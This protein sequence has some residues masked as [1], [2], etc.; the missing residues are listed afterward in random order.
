ML[1][2]GGPVF[3][4]SRD[5]YNY[6]VTLKNEGE[7]EAFIAKVKEK[8]YKAI[9]CPIIDLDNY[10]L[11]DL[12][13]KR[14][15]EEDIIIA[16]AGTWEN[17]L[18]LNL[19]DRAKNRD[20]M[21]QTIL[22]ADAL[23]A[24]TAINT[25]GALNFGSHR[26]HCAANFTEEAFEAVLEQTRELLDRTNPKHTKLSYEIYQWHILDT[27]KEIKRMV[28]AINDDRFGVHLDLVNLLN[29]PRR[30]WRSYDVAKEFIDTLGEH[31]VSC[32][33][34]DVWMNQGVNDDLEFHEVPAGQGQVDIAGCMKLLSALPGEIPYMM[35]HLTSEEQYTQVCGYLRGLAAENN[36]PLK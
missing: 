10:D 28:D 2:L 11:I 22:L 23:G 18:D 9:Y 31:L 1:V 36:I 21:V 8:G 3:M 32:H 5:M 20:K 7:L 26:N 12:T 24:R 4:D 13:R 30:Y 16:E 33:V 17:L 25:S 15:A 29:C 35:E 14:L 27:T 19:E 6:G 34:K